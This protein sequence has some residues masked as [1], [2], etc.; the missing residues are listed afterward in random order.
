MMHY[1]AKKSGNGDYGSLNASH[2]RYSALRAEDREE[3]YRE[4]SGHAGSGHIASRLT[5]NYVALRTNR[6]C[7][8]LPLTLAR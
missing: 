8:A 7:V 5:S 6:N 1:D 2:N 3:S 4:G